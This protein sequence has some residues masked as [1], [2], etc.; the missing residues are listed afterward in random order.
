MPLHPFAYDPF[1]QRSIEIISRGTSLFV[2]APTGAGKTVIADFIIAQ[3]LQQGQRVIYTAPVKALSNQKFRDFT[4][5]HGDRVGMMTGDVTINPTAPV[6]I[7]TTEIYRNT[8][9]ENPTRLSQCAWVLF[10]EVHYLDDPERGTVW[11]EAIMF[12]PQHINLL[13]LSATIPNVEELASWIRQIHGRPI[14]VVVETNRP[15][16]L[17]LLFQCQNQ[18]IKSPQELRAIGYRG[19]AD[20][21]HPR[22]QGWRHGRRHE[23]H[24][25][26]RWPI[27]QNRLDSLIRH[28][29]ESER[30]PGIFF[31]FGRRRAEDLAWEASR[32]SLVTSAET[33][34]LRTMFEELC[35]RYQLSDEQAVQSL[36]YLIQRGVAFHHAGMLP[37]VKEVVEQCFLS[38]LI[39]FIVTTETFALGINMPARSVVIDTLKKRLG[40]RIDL[41]RSRQFSQM[42]GRAG[43]RGMDEAGFVYLRV[44][45]STITYQEVMRVI[46]SRPESV[47]SRLNTSYAT[48]LNLFRRHGLGL[49]RLFPQTFYYFQ[50]SGARREA[51]LSLMQRKLDLLRHLGYLDAERLS[52]K[53]EF[54]AFLYGYELLL[55]ELHA[56]R[57]LD[58]LDPPSLSVLL[59]AAVYE[60]RPGLRLP[61]AHAISRRLNELCREPLARIHRAEHLFRVQPKSKA[62]HFQLA[63][64]MEAWFHGAPFSRLA[65]LCEVDEGEIVR[66]FRM[67]VQL[68]RQLMDSPAADDALRRKARLALERINRDVVDAEAQLRLG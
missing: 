38:R 47:L 33:E 9:L 53:G 63:A 30:L 68:L 67:T 1:Q 66:Y 65:K 23:R 27:H 54:A 37:T 39:K 62:P 4:S 13:A 58:A 22:R 32:L 16:P 19:R 29:Q 12:T 42:A 25:V 36:S 57:Y 7:M 17:H 2:A 55:T 35:A 60:P 41:I 43:R 49:L 48:L 18:V 59:A 11:E 24:H 31:T 10:D 6:L 56:Q 52:S 26:E 21:P 44:N 15:V 8:L 40:G 64:A 5:Q 14:E 20:G 46:H 45:P 34:Q 61:K 50:T 51:G 3:A 28:L